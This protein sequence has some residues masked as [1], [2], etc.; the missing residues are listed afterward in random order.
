MFGANY[1]ILHQRIMQISIL[2]HF[3]FQVLKI[4]II[5]QNYS[6]LFKEFGTTLI[7]VVKYFYRT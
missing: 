4:R 2:T 3:D 1:R 7:L 6:F 5:I